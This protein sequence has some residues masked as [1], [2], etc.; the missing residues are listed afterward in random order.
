MDAPAVPATVGWGAQWVGPHLGISVQGGWFPGMFPSVPAKA[1]AP[2]ACPAK[3]TSAGHGSAKLT[4]AGHGS[5]IEA[6][7]V[8]RKIFCA[9]P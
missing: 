6:D 4:S 7:E 9:S 1:Q 3:L 2:A 8:A 5:A